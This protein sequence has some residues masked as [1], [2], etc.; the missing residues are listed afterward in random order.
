M[1]YRSESQ[2]L[3]ILNNSLTKYDGERYNNGVNRSDIAGLST[4]NFF[5]EKKETTS[6]SHYKQ[7]KRRYHTKIINRFEIKMG[8]RKFEG[9]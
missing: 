5:Y 1:I 4:N 9:K 6:V 2:T 8:R 3:F 7:F